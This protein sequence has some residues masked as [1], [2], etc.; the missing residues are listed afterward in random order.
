MKTRT[1]MKT[2]SNPFVIAH[3][4]SKALAFAIARAEGAVDLITADAVGHA[5]MAC[6]HPDLPM[7]EWVRI[8]DKEVQ[9]HA[10]P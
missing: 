7:A 2:T 10:A 5:A 1:T 9:R 8:I 3:R 6:W 4:K